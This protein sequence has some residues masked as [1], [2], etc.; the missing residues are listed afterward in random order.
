LKQTGQPASLIRSRT[1]QALVLILLVSVLL[2]VTVAIWLGNEVDAP[3]LLTDQRSYHALGVRLSTGHGFSF[4]RPW[5]PFYLPADSP[6]AHWSYLYSLFIAAVYSVFGPQVIAA[7]LLQAILGGMVLPLAVFQLT[8]RVL[9]SASSTHL[10]TALRERGLNTATLPLIAAGVAAIYFYFVLYAATL[11]T[12]TFFITALLWSLDRAI[13]LADTPTVKNG[14]VLGVGLAVATLLRQSVLPGIA[15]IV[16]WLLW[17]AWRANRLR[18]AL[19]AIVVSG[20]V[21]VVAIAPFTLRNYRVF[22]QMLLLNSNAGYAMYSAQHPMHGTS[23]QAFEAAP[24]PLDLPLG[25]EAH[26][27]EI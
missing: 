3:P 20:A 16:L 7:R 6:T 2:R 19:G 26:S 5:Y 13:A 10:L 25:N 11:M 21:L 22:G 1:F 24:L 4:D 14:L 15:V 17:A 23:F 27:I 18:Q 8:R 9:E 12:E